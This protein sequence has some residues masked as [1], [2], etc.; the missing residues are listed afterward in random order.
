MAKTGIVVNLLGLI[1]ITLFMFAVG[2]P[3][4]GISPGIVPPWAAP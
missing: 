2:V 1:L 4:L 3:V